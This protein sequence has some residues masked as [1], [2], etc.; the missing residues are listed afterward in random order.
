MPTPKF[1]LRGRDLAAAGVAAGPA[2]GALLRELRAWWMDGGCAG[3]VRAE[4]ARRV[5]GQRSTSAEGAAL[6]RPTSQP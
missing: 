3:D 5:R 6:F 4:L 1:P 2:M